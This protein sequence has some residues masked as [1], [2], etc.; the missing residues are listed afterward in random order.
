MSAFHF[1]KSTETWKVYIMVTNG[2][3]TEYRAFEIQQLKIIQ[4]EIY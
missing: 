2:N 4:I 1:T 3:V